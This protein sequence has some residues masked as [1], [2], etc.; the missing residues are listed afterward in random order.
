MSK[1]TVRGVE[2]EYFHHGK[3]IYEPIILIHGASSSALIWD[4]TQK[5]LELFGFESYAIGLRGAGRSKHSAILKDYH[6]SNYALDVLAFLDALQIEQ[7]II[8]GHS[9]G[10]IVS[11]YI[12]ANDPERV[13]RL[14]Q[15]SGP[16]PV[17]TVTSNKTDGLTNSSYRRYVTPDDFSH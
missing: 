3:S 5:S 10:T 1:I 13:A 8:I 16:S 17:K 11:N 6:P 14:V 2:L 9:L 4:S 12:V 7:S 15:I